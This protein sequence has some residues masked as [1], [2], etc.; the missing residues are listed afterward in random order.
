MKAVSERC[1]QVAEPAVSLVEGG[2]GVAGA[3][4]EVYSN[5]SSA[6]N[7]A[8][9]TF[10]RRSSETR[11]RERR[12]D[13]AEQEQL[14]EAAALALAFFGASRSATDASRKDSAAALMSFCSFL[15]SKICFVGDLPFWSR[16]TASRADS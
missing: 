1:G 2:A 4:V 15:S 5:S 8:S 9:S 11:E 13:D 6:P 14:A 10:L 3:V 16:P 7:S 12:A